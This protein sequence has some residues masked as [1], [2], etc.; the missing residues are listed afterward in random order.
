MKMSLVIIITILL[1]IIL[2]ITFLFFITKRDTKGI[3]E[4]EIVQKVPTPQKQ[5]NKNPYIDLRQMAFNVSTEKLEII[6]PNN[7]VRVYGMIMDMDMGGGIATLVAYSTGDASMYLSTGGG[8][9]GGGQH[10]AVNKAAKKLNDQAQN[11]LN[12]ASLVSETPIPSNGG[13]NIYLLTNKGKYLIKEQLSNFD[14]EKSSI[15][16][17]FY[18]ANDVIT[19]LRMSTTK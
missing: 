9:V 15:Q 14:N 12:K 17:L 18:G 19:Q 3:P 2:A 16:L 13:V 7:E 8:V 1:G 6:F 10:D 5:P 11:Y 4:K